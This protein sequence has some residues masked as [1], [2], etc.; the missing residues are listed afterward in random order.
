LVGNPSI[1][2]WEPSFRVPG[3]GIRKATEKS[4]PLPNLPF[5]SRDRKGLHPHLQMRT[6]GAALHALHLVRYIRFTDLG[7][8]PGLRENPKRSVTN[9]III[10]IYEKE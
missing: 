6:A 4:R 5:V 1:P 8:M 9:C 2:D 7:R 10:A 3:I